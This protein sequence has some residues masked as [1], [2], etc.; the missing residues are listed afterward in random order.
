MTRA[1]CSSH[2]SHGAYAQQRDRAERSGEY[3]IEARRELA[4]RR[5]DHAGSQGSKALAYTGVVSA[6]S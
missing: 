1:G 3:Q 2:A 6:G 4:A 5:A